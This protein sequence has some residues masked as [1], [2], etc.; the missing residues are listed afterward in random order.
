VN[1]V[2]VSKAD[3]VT[4]GGKDVLTL[5][6]K[7]EQGARPES[8]SLS[9]VRIFINDDLPAALSI[10]KMLLRH[11]EAVVLR[12][13]GE[14]EKVLIPQD[15]FV[16]GGFGEDEELFPESQNTGRPLSL[17]RDYFTFPE[18]FLF[19]DIFGLDSLPPSDMP[20]SV[21]SLEIRFDRRLS[22]GVLLTKE[23]FKL[24]CA[25]AVNIFRRDAEPV[26]VDGKRSE[27][28]LTA[29]AVHPEC[30][31]IHSVES[32]V[33]VDRVSG[34]RREYER[35][36]GL[37]GGRQRFYSVRAGR[38]SGDG[39]QFSGDRRMKLSMNGY[40]TAGGRLLNE[41]LH[42]DAWQTNGQLARKIL[43]DGGGALRKAPPEFP[44]YITFTNITIPTHQINPPFDDR[45]LW[46]FLS[47]LSATYSSFSDA[48]KLKD[49]L[50]V[51][52]W[53]T[54]PGEKRSEIEAILSVSVK[55]CDLIVDRAVIRGTEMNVCVDESV[56]PEENIF[57]L[58][59]VLAR[60]LSCMASIN[61]FLKLVVTMMPSGKTFEW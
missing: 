61:T 8:L 5:S 14:R 13:G 23:A 28:D 21:L 20:P 32:V 55:P 6:F 3:I 51:Y 9:P 38:Q 30:F 49:F 26:V 45:Y 2:A 34:E 12:D 46:A 54:A 35:Y 60:S 11:V 15:T 52:D 40:Q 18:R 50:R 25:P 59:G 10:R 29:D 43:A 42:I 53:V 39:R 7:L 17:L 31:E 16:E 24:H 44:D 48:G 41:T 37:G 22:S 57:L 1:P 58:G 4:G 33:G 27:Y 47:H 19:V 56:A 36:C